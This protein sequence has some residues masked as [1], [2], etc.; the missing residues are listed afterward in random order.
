[1]EALEGIAT[2]IARHYRLGD[3]L[4]LV[5][6]A[7]QEIAQGHDGTAPCL[8]TD[9][10]DETLD[11]LFSAAEQ[12]TAAL[13]AAALEKEGLR[14]EVIPDIKGDSLNLADLEDRNMI[15]VSIRLRRP[16]AGKNRY[17]SGVSG[18][19]TVSGGGCQRKIWGGCNRG[20]YRGRL[21][22]N[23]SLFGNTRGCIAAAQRKREERFLKS[24]M[25][26]PWS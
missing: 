13:M 3:K 20:S 11:L 2:Y 8:K 24:R 23:C 12:Q 21:G 7:L 9:V 10:D 26:R 14:T 6:A 22:C 4:V 5:V 25:R 1:M 18:N 16:C 17:R 15:F 19:R